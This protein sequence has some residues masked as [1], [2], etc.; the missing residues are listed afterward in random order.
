[1]SECLMFSFLVE[2]F[3]P[4]IPFLLREGILH[5]TKCNGVNVILNYLSHNAINVR[6]P[7]VPCPLL[8]GFFFSNTRLKTQS[9]EKNVSISILMGFKL[10]VMEGLL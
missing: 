2:V 8:T 1:M 5:E 6:D 4:Q 7:Q 3:L 10:S 9:L